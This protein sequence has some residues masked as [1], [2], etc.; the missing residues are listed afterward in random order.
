MSPPSISP[1]ITAVVSLK[2][3]NYGCLHALPLSP[4]PL[5]GVQNHAKIGSARQVFLGACKDCHACVWLDSELHM[6][7]IIIW[8]WLFSGL[9][10]KQNKNEKTSESRSET[11]VS[12]CQQRE[13]CWMRNSENRVVKKSFLFEESEIIQ[14]IWVL[15]CIMLFSAFKWAPVAHSQSGQPLG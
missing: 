15:F 5:F 12:E 6:K 4:T 3:P 2:I 7:R 8:K 13:Q 9:S 1:Q 11:N 14:N 10:G